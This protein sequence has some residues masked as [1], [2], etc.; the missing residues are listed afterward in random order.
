MLPDPKP[1]LLIMRLG[2]RQIDLLTRLGGTA[3]FGI[4]ALAR[5]GTAKHQKAVA[6]VHQLSL[7]SS[8]G[9]LAMKCPRM[10][11]GH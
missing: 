11:S 9:I 3:V 10:P 8:G 1:H 6:A 4:E 7:R 2:R 5:P